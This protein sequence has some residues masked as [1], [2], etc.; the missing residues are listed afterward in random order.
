MK[1]S[2]VCLSV[3]FITLVLGNLDLHTVLALSARQCC[4]DIVIPF[5]LS[6]VR[7]IFRGGALVAGAVVI[8]GHVSEEGGLALSRVV[9]CYR[10]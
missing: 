10:R 6:Y 1:E 3:I 4:L 2:M 7:L 5:I 9:V 8:I